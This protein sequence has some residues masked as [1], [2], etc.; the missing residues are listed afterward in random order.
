MRLGPFH[1]S[2]P[3]EGGS[4][5]AKEPPCAKKVPEPTTQENGQEDEIPSQRKEEG[6]GGGRYE[7]KGMGKPNKGQGNTNQ[8]QRDCPSKESTIAPREIFPNPGK[9]GSSGDNP[10]ACYNFNTNRDKWKKT[11]R[12][13]AA[14]QLLTEKQGRQGAT[15]SEG[16]TKPKTLESS[17]KQPRW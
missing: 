5:H 12:P 13:K 4:S 6:K 3:E 10:Y 8:G 16:D 11:I 9:E 17:P 1:I 15:T 2:E 14:L 7:G